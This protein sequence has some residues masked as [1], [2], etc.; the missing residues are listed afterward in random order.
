MPGQRISSLSSLPG[1]PYQVGSNSPDSLPPG[2]LPTFSNQSFLRTPSQMAPLGV[3][4][5][6]A[7]HG[8][9]MGSQDSFAQVGRGR[10][11]LSCHPKQTLNPPIA[12]PGDGWGFHGGQ[13]LRWWGVYDAH[14][15]LPA[16]LPQP[17]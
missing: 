8:N 2:L 11:I 17:R 9:Y 13:V 10:P 3:P 6:P 7:I 12:S 5:P 16:V 4:Y 1:K 15:R 14:G